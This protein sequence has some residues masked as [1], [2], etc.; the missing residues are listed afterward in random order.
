LETCRID[1]LACTVHP[2]GENAVVCCHGLYSNKESRKYIEMAERAVRAGLS[3]V[4]FDFSGCGESGGDFSYELEDRVKDL[5]KIMEY[6]SRRFGRGHFA[7]LGSSFG[8][9][10]ALRY[11][12]KNEVLATVIMSTPY[13]VRFGSYETDVLADAEQCSHVLIMHGTRDELVPPAHA[14]TL[15]ERVQEPKKMLL[16]DTDHSFSDEIERSRA[17]DKALRWIL[18]HME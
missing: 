14:S 6:A 4:R 15:Y 16:F 11:A 8:G 7:L 9:M 13:L 3:C 17:L 5:E 1:G 2:A 12:A 10:T 18:E